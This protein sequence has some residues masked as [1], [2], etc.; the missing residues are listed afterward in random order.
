MAFES[1][2]HKSSFSTDYESWPTNAYSVRTTSDGPQALIQYGLRVMAHKRLFSLWWAHQNTHMDRDG[3]ARV[4][5]DMDYEWFSMD[6]EWFSTNYDWWAHQRTPKYGLRVIE[7]GLQV[8]GP[9]EYIQIW[10]R[11]FQYGLRVIE[12]GL[13]VTGQWVQIGVYCDWSI[14]RCPY[15]LP[16]EHRCFC[17]PPFRRLVTSLSSFH[18]LH[19]VSYTHLRAHET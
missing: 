3:P 4:P 14:T 9:Q 8:M 5:L 2:D 1:R 19:S 6:Y 7:Y 11:V 10:I 15:L 13:R 18:S 16:A 17:L 12:Y